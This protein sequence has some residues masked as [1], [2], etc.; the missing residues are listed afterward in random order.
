MSDSHLLDVLL[1]SAVRGVH[2]RAHYL[3]VPTN[4]QGL[5]WGISVD[6]HQSLT[7]HRVWGLSF[8]P[9]HLTVVLKLP[10]VRG[11]IEIS[12]CVNET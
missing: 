2:D 12:E 8:K 7:H 9:E 1:R 5:I 10:R 11:L 3:G 4:H 6:P